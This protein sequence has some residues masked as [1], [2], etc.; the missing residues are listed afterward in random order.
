[1]SFDQQLADAPRVQNSSYYEEVVERIHQNAASDNHCVRQCRIDISRLQASQE[2]LRVI[3]NSTL[4]EL[5]VNQHEEFEIN[6][7]IRVV[8][9]D[10]LQARNRNQL[11]LAD[12]LHKR[13]EQLILNQARV[14]QRKAKIEVRLR[15]YTQFT[16]DAALEQREHRRHIEE[17]H[18]ITTPE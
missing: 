9:E 16:V 7:E 6:E 17:V 5:R 13:F 3:K 15:E 10:E 2:A 18:G 14:L 11:R 12:R 8:N 1:M 4:E